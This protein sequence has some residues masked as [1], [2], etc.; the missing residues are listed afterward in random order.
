MC[1][2]PLH[3]T[4]AHAFIQSFSDRS[5]LATTT[6][7]GP[8]PSKASVRARVRAGVR[9]WRPKPNPNPSPNR[10]PCPNPNPKPTQ[11]FLLVTARAAVQKNDHQTDRQI[12]P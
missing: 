1:E 10:S 4:M 3:G 5:D 8:P 2:V 12:H 9:S 7:V 6:L 11:A